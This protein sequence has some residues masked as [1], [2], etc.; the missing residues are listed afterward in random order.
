MLF[1]SHDG[2]RRK[3]INAA[4]RP[5]HGRYC[6][7]RAKTSENV[8]ERTQTDQ[9]APAARITAVTLGNCETSGKRWTHGQNVLKTWRNGRNGGKRKH[10]GRK[11][12]EKGSTCP[13]VRFTAVTVGIGQKRRENVAK[14]VETWP[15]GRNGGKRLNVTRSPRSRRLRCKSGEPCKNGV[16]RAE[17]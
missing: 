17:T 14:R 4:R 1:R 15:I 13:D 16:G 11:R 8:A 9:H 12:T 7:N 5:V 10:D 2:N 6:G 3:R